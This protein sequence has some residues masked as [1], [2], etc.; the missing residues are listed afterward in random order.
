MNKNERQITY[1][2]TGKLSDERSNQSEQHQWQQ[3]R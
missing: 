1:N 3:G 2:N